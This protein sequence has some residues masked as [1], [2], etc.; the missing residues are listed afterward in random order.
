ME[1]TEQ[2][3]NEPLLP[4]SAWSNNL[5]YLQTLFKAKKA[6]DRIEKESGIIRRKNS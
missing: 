2:S 4:R 1:K 3:F 5:T 6:L